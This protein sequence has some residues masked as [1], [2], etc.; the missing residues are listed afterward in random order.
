MRGSNI[1]INI[2]IWIWIDAIYTPRPRETR[3]GEGFPAVVG[4]FVPLWGSVLWAGVGGTIYISFGI[5]G[6]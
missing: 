1:D 3:G 4:Q 5:D 2:W 6:Y